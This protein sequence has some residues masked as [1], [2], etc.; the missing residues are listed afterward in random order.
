VI[1]FVPRHNKLGQGFSKKEVVASRIHPGRNVKAGQ[2]AASW[3]IDLASL[4][5]PVLLC[6]WCRDKFPANKFKYRQYFSPDRSGVTSGFCVNGRCDA[7][8][9]ETANTPGGGVMF[10]AEETY[11][12]NCIDPCEA[13]RNARQAWRGVGSAWSMISKGKKNGN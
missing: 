6:T 4:R 12:L 11:N 8:K 2:T 9:G 10:I 1:G 3:V 13:R 5:K 7:C